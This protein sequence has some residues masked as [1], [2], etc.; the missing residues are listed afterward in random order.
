[1]LWLV[2]RL[3]VE[4]GAAKLLSGD[5]TWWNLTAMVSYYETAPLPTW[6][7]WYAHQMPLWAHQACALFTFVV[8]LGAP[9]LIW[10]P[11]K[12]RLV[13]FVLMIAMQVSVVLTA[14]YGFFNYLTMA[15]CLFVLDDGHL[16][17]LIAAPRAPASATS[18]TAGQHAAFGG[19][20]S[21]SP[22]YSCHCRWCRSCRS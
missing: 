15:L 16:D 9:L 17:W 21:W 5:P 3:H 12:L 22:S 4:S 2:F 1:M 19:A 13:A 6:L 14:N 18:A 20:G 8:E 11:R 10:G 7:G